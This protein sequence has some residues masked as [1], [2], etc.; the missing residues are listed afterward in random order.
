MSRSC[1]GVLFLAATLA[2]SSRAA[3]FPE[4]FVARLDLSAPGMETIGRLARAGRTDSALMVWRNQFLR[5]L[6]V[7]DLGQF[8]WHS[9]QTHP[10]PLSF[11]AFLV[12]SMTEARYRAQSFGYDWVDSYGWRG[13]PGT[14]G[15]VDW[16]APLAPASSADYTKDVYGTFKMFTPLATK[17]HQT[18]SSVYLDKYFEL[19][20]QFGR[21][22]KNQILA[23][24]AAARAGYDCD[25]SQNAQVALDQGFRVH[26]MVR[27]LALIAKSL[28]PDDPHP[29]WDVV[30]APLVRPVGD[31]ALARVDAETLAR[32]AWSL[33]VDHPYAMFWRFRNAGAVPNQRMEG[34]SALSMYGALFPEFRDVRDSLAAM[35]DASMRDHLEGST[36]R[37]GGFLEQSFN[38]NAGDLGAMDELLAL[39]DGPT[40]SVRLPTPASI[41][42]MRDRVLG[43]RRLL[44]LGLDPFGRMPR[45]GNNGVAIQDSAWAAG[46]DWTKANA[47]ATS[48]FESQIR[49]GTA[50]PVLDQVKTALS[51]A[52]TGIPSFTS[53]AFPHVGY[54]CLRRDWSHASPWLWMNGARASR[55]HDSPDAGAV[56]VASGARQFLVGSGVQW[57][58]TTQCPASLQAEFDKFNA[59]FSEASGW[60]SSTVL[61]DSTA[62]NRGTTTIAPAS[63]RD[64]LWS[65]SDRFDLVATRFVDG[66]GSISDAVHQRTVIQLRGLDAWIVS[67]R[68]TGSRSH[69]WTQVWNFSPEFPAGSVVVDSATGTIRTDV[70]SGPSWS[71]TVHATTSRTFA[72]HHGEKGARYLGW[73]KTDM[74]SSP[75][76][77]T[78]VHVGLR[79][80]TVVVASLMAVRPAGVR[81]FATRRDSSDALRAG[82]EIALDGGAALRFQECRHA[83]CPLSWN[84]VSSLA[85]SALVRRDASGDLSGLV[86]GSTDGTLRANGR[87][88]SIPF[89]DFEWTLRGTDWTAREIKVPDTFGWTTDAFP[90]QVLWTQEPRSVSGVLG[91]SV[92]A[93]RTAS[94]GGRGLLFMDAEPDGPVELELLDVRGAVSDRRPALLHQGWNTPD[95]GPSPRLRLARVKDGRGRVLAT[96]AIPPGDRP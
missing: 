23:L 20:G 64:G 85:R 96:A 4:Q 71:Q 18:R 17:F 60:K 95:C 11:A 6:R 69:A 38:Y 3:T 47:A 78:D 26:Q 90:R 59:Y 45:N 87:N 62:Q 56:Q 35:V 70:A 88:L 75:V 29:A 77:K 27:Q 46:Y 53:A 51:G 37:D 48:S 55:G 25:W 5:R 28:Q 86:L 50:D 19:V 10:R 80:D 43:F 31:A 83:S 52:T 21:N 72:R 42:L 33:V 14:I 44:A 58:S 1:A 54:Y 66:Y 79:G 81:T 93:A 39:W 76:P 49:S 89:R 41:G 12:D 34:L 91:G 68:L 15:T 82:F 40:E 61:C 94:A 16:V 8:G 63:F 67:D 84:G 92:S 13:R 2:T 73:W 30:L 9:Y 74:G 24:P 32:I 7:Q 36:F 65:T 22:Q 57:Y